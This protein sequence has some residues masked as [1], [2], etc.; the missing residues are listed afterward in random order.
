[1]GRRR[2]C[3]HAVAA[4]NGRRD[5]RALRHGHVTSK[6]PCRLGRSE[7]NSRKRRGLDARNRQATPHRHSRNRK[8]VALPGRAAAKGVLGKTRIEEGRAAVAGKLY[9]RGGHFG[10]DF[11]S[12]Q[13][14]RLGRSRDRVARLARRFAVSD[15]IGPGRRRDSEGSDHVGRAGHASQHAVALGGGGAGCCRRSCSRSLTCSCSC[16]CTCSPAGAWTHHRLVIVA[17]RRRSADRIGI[18][19]HRLVVPGTGPRA[20]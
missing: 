11:A 20:G 16:S 15:H 2:D 14:L 5:G 6:G 3:R 8:H 4:P 7:T 19:G 17:Q 18:S 1:M 13:S 12:K 9:Q 10:H